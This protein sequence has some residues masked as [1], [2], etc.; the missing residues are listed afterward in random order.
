MSQ[1]RFTDAIVYSDRLGESDVFRGSFPIYNSFPV[2]S[3]RT[4]FPPLITFSIQAEDFI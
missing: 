3:G 2:S 4:N 1:A